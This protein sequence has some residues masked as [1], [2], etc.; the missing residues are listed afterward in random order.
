MPQAAEKSAPQ[1][2]IQR[3]GPRGSVETRRWSMTGRHLGGTVVPLPETNCLPMNQNPTFFPGK[4]H[5]NGGFSM[6]IC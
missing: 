4:Y 2:L 5:Q 1:P 6:A 3:P